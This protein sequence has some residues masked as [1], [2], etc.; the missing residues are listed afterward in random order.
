MSKIKAI[1]SFDKK[2][3]MNTYNRYPIALLKGKGVKVWDIE[4]KEY[5]DFLGGIAVNILGH[6]HPAIIDA[7]TSQAKELI[8]ISNLY[9][10]PSTAKL[11]ECLSVNG[12]LDKVFF[13]NSGAE[14]NEGA[15]K[16]ARKY[17]WRKGH[18][19]KHK[20]ITATNSFHGR[21]LATLAASYKQE[22]KEGFG[23]LPEG[24]QTL[25]WNNTQKFLE[26][27][28]ETTAAVLIEPIQ[29]EGGVQVASLD[30][31]LVQHL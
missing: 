15:I 3:L 11:A 12:G 28:D 27:I 23:P 6:C 30:S 10:H 25:P 1:A 31:P 29:G 7:V 2:Y 20:I 18:L 9:Y 8:H 5:L 22:L 17:Q 14:A 24:F 4:G 13:C 16:L 19:K 21:T 26:N